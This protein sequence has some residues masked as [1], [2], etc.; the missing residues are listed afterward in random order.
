MTF[1]Q[2]R[3]SFGRLSSFREPGSS[4]LLMLLLAGDLVYIGFHCLHVLTPYFESWTFSIQRDAG[5]AEVFQY[6]KFLWIILLLM[7]I[8]RA[9]RELHYGAWV[10]VFLYFLLD[11]S[12]QIHEKFGEA[13]ADHLNLTAP[14]NLR[15]QDIGELIVIALA[16][17]FLLLVLVL[18]YWRGSPA[19]RRTTKDMVLLVLVLAVVGIGADMAQVAYPGEGIV[20]LIL[21]IIEDGGELVVVSFMLWY[22]FLLTLRKGRPPAYLWDAL[23]QRQGARVQ[24]PGKSDGNKREQ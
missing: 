15:P 4:L 8:M 19:F 21:V 24:P 17:S 5:Y 20:D 3:A 18:S 6:M 22:F 14:F 1:T 9:T 13:L 12:L 23:F 2:V 10:L 11:D 16:G 7:L